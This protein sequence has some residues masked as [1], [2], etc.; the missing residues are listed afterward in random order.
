MPTEQPLQQHP[1]DLQQR[2]RPYLPAVSANSQSPSI[3]D[4]CQTPT[5]SGWLKVAADCNTGAASHIA[6]ADDRSRIHGQAGLSDSIQVQFGRMF[7]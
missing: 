7:Y 5:L 1:S 3:E 4:I 6:T 2:N